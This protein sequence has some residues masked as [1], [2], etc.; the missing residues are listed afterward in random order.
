MREK[1]QEEIIKMEL[2]WRWKGG[3]VG[4][5]EERKKGAKGKKEGEGL[6]FNYFLNVDGVITDI[7]L[8][9]LA[10]LLFSPLKAIFEFGYLF[11]LG[12]R[13]LI[14]KYKDS[15]LFNQSDAN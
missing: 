1:K 6:R 14:R 2:T 4:V 8:I 5:K 12:K 10:N 11:K 13:R 3:E 15:R 9:S 7:L